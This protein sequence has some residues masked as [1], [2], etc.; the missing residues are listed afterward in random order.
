MSQTQTAALLKQGR[1]S[2]RLEVYS[3]IEGDTG[4]YFST[5]NTYYMICAGFSVSGN[6]AVT[7]S[8]EGLTGV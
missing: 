3:K 4:Y 5:T 2:F 1:D 8:V 7:A 6:A